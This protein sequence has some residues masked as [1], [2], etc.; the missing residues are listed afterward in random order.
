M[1]P[2]RP[3]RRLWLL[4]APVVIVA[5]VALATPLVMT[6]RCDLRTWEMQPVSCWRNSWAAL[7][8]GVRDN[9]ANTGLPHVIVPSSH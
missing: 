2:Q 9:K 3:R 7:G 6:S 5:G 8:A 4:A 1:L